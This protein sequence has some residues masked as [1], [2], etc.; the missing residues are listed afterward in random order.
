MSILRRLGSA[1]LVLTSCLF[2]CAETDSIE[3]LDAPE[4]SPKEGHNTGGTN[5]A[6]SNDFLTLQPSLVGMANTPLVDP[7]TMNVNSAIVTILLQQ[8]GGSDLFKYAVRCGLTSAQGQ[9]AVTWA[10]AVLP[11]TYQGMG[12]LGTTAGWLTGPLSGTGRDDLFACIVAHLNPYGIEV[13]LVLSGASVTDDGI[14][15]PDFTVDEAL[16]VVDF[17][18]SL[19]HYTVWPTDQFKELCVADPAVALED[20]VCG[21]HPALCNLDVGASIQLDC[22]Y[23]VAAGGYYCNVGNPPVARPA[24]KT[25][26]KEADFMRLNKRCVRR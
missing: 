25:S 9:N 14:E 11:K 17:P 3:D 5:G 10:T 7:G 12:H 24:L 19:P 1:A 23:D 22:F 26:L 13:P 8:A 15:Y 4:L 2:G 21:Q 20:R 6:S 16:W 18:N